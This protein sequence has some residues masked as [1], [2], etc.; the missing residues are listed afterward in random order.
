M[1][2]TLQRVGGRFLSQ[3]L[4]EEAIQALGPNLFPRQKEGM[5]FSLISDIRS[6]AFAADFLECFYPQGLDKYAEPKPGDM[7]LT[8]ICPF[9]NRVVPH[10]SMETRRN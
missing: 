1:G 10:I 2:E 3:W 9:I 5:G 7:S 4:K 8:E 6:G